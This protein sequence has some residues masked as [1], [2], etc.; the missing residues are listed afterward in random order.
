MVMF[1]DVFFNVENISGKDVIIFGS[2]R[3][4]PHT[5]T[6]LFK[7]IPGLSESRI[8]DAL[9]SPHGELYMLSVVH[10]KLSILDFR[11]ATIDNVRVDP[12]HIAALNI[13]KR[14]E[15]LGF[16]GSS[17]KWVTAGG[18]GEVEAPLYREEDII[19]L[20]RAGPHTSGYLSREDWLMFSNISTG[21]RIWQYC[22]IGRDVGVSLKIKSFNNVEIPFNAGSIVSGSAVIV[23]THSTGEA[24]GTRWWDRFGFSST[25]K[26]IS[27]MY[28]DI[29]LNH[30]P[31]PDEDCRV[32]F[33]VVLPAGAE[34]PE[35][36]SGAPPFVRKVRAEYF[37]FVDLNSS[38]SEMIK[39][40]K[41]FKSDTTFETNVKILGD[42]QVRGDIEAHGLTFGNN[43]GSYYVLTS[44][45]LGRGTWQPSPI[46]S[47]GPPTNCYDGQLWMKTPEFQPYVYDGTRGKW[48][49][50]SERSVCAWSNQ[51]VAHSYLSL[52]GS[53]TGDLIPYN[54]TLIGLVASCERGGPW[55]AELHVDNA[56]V[57]GASMGVGSDGRG[58]KLDLNA[59]FSVGS[60]LQFFVNGHNIDKPKIEA[61]FRKNT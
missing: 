42:T 37:D 27:H 61:I 38:K 48:L 49:C 29:I 45:S 60:R 36:Y 19:H 28:D 4:R 18:G 17:L 7:S 57:A 25:T 59:D 9:R 47:G 11:L 1:T 40:E 2:Y 10:K 6:D 33:L 54:C 55:T 20:G 46:V 14:G 21:F 22:D 12:A 43:A 26:I 52:S 13:P 30:A 35:S 56:L 32:Y 41:R 53:A 34:I 3:L 58:I 5:R 31:P 24:P 23:K 39:G 50:V 8:L 15:V 51:L 16:D 44:N